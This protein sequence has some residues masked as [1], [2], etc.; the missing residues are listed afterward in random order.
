M[1]TKIIATA[2]IHIRNTKRMDEYQEK[3][4]TFI[5]KCKEIANE[6]GPDKTRI[7]IVGDLFHNKLD[8]SGEGYTM[9]AWL[10]RELDKIAKTIVI[11]GNHDMNMDNLS[12]LDPISALFSMQPFTKTYYLDRE[13]D[14]ES[15]CIADDNIVWCLYS[16]FDSFNK[17]NIAETRLKN[18]DKTFI[19]LFHGDMKSAKDD[20]GYQSDKG[21]DPSY[22]DELDCCLMGHIHKR[23]CIKYEGTPLVYCGSL[24]QQ[25]HGENLSKH[26][27]IVWDVKNSSYDDVDFKDDKYGY[28]DFSIESPDDIDNDKEEIINL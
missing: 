3:L 9:A 2:D 5:K 25:D 15:R 21:L 24:I 19:G 22:F 8:I 18:P 1:V 23:Q 20:S 11:A 28:Y 10:L 7:V 4:E 17:P 12:R 6:N 27:F 13:A 14:Y 26:G 16:S